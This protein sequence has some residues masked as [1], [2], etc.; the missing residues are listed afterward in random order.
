[1]SK[2]F[3]STKVYLLHKTIF[4]TL[5]DTLMQNHFQDISRYPHAK[6]VLDKIERKGYY[7]LEEDFYDFMMRIK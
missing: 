5:V 6:P 4:K 2:D 3:L 7:Y 1:M